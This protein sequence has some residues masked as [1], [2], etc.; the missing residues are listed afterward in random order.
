MTYIVYDNLKEP[1][2]LVVNNTLQECRVCLVSYVVRRPL[3]RYKRRLIFFSTLAL[4]FA[5]HSAS[6]SAKEIWLLGSYCVQ[7]CSEET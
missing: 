1:A 3:V 2:S 5:A 7:S 6:Y 4:C